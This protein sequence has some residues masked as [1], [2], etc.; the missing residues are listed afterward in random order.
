MARLKGTPN[1]NKDMRS[2]TVLVDPEDYEKLLERAK[3]E[4]RSVAYLIRRSVKDFINNKY[5]SQAIDDAHDWIATNRL[6]KGNDQIDGRE[7]RYFIAD[8]MREALSDD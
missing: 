6:I 4:E 1:L 5:Y 7:F 2:V 3:S 8:E